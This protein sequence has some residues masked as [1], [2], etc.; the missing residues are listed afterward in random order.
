MVKLEAGFRPSGSLPVKET[1][2][3]EL[4]FVPVDD[5]FGVRGGGAGFE[6]NDPPARTHQVDDPDEGRQPVPGQIG[7]D[8]NLD[9]LGLFLG[10]DRGVAEIHLHEPPRFFLLGVLVGLP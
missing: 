1:V 4:D 2:G 8:T 7:F 9:S 3:G 6:V 5:L 10:R